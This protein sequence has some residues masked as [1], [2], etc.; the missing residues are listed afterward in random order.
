MG[1]LGTLALSVLLLVAAPEADARAQC[2]AKVSSCAQCHEAP[3]C[4]I[5][6]R[7]DEL[8]FGWAWPAFFPVLARVGALGR[9]TFGDLTWASPIL[10]VALFTEV[11]LL[12]FYVIERW[13]RR[14]AAP[15]STPA[16]LPR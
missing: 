7:T 14:A 9:I 10:P 16:S 1:K 5:V 6:R 11:V 4:A 13:P 2:A 8:A 15:S 12:V 3:D